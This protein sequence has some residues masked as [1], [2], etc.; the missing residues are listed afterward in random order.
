MR[1]LLQRINI[2]RF[3]APMDADETIQYIDHR[4]KM[5]GASFDACFE[6]NC[7][8]LIYKM[9]NGVPR[10]INQLCDN[11]LLVCKAEKLRKVNRKTLKKAGT[12][13]R[14][15][16]L[17]TPSPRAGRAA[18]SRKSTS[19]AAVFCACAILLILLWIYGYRG[20]LGD[21]VQ[22]FLHSLHSSM[23][24]PPVAVRQPISESAASPVMPQAAI[25]PDESTAKISDLVID[26]PSETAKTDSS[27]MPS[28]ATL[29]ATKQPQQ[30]ESPATP[31]VKTG[32]AGSLPPPAG[33][34]IQSVNQAPR[35]LDPIRVT[36]KN[37][38]TLLGI[39]S[40]FFPEDKLNGMIKIL[41]ANPMIDDIDRIYTGQELIIPEA[42]S[43]RKEPN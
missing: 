17:F 8:D 35:L 37:G 2:N 33:K 31:D 16:V 40:R 7:R 6:P 5:A 30:S 18:S 15:D 34:G 23:L 10:S 27:R 14:S 19:V 29:P 36:V 4:L 12:A 3:L 28:G 41:A 1:Q 24:M 25:K 43:I 38:D 13:L 42:G 21:R 22:Y 26:N 9:T 20:W 39:A 32:N 11:A